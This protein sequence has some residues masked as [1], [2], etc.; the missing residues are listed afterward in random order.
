MTA[1][2]STSRRSKPP[3]DRAGR[4]AEGHA[5][6]NLLNEWAAC[7]RLDRPP[8]PGC[9]L[10]LPESFG[11]RFSIFVDTE[12]EFDWA[13]PH[14]R[15]ERSTRTMEALPNIHR[16]LRSYGSAPIYLVD[17][18]VATDQRCV[19]T[20][21]EYL[22]KGECAIGA[23]LHPWVNPPFDEALNVRNSFPGNLPV[24]T[25]R[26]KIERLTETIE[27]AFG[28][29]PIV[30][31]AG[32][33]GV[34][35]NTASLLRDAGYR[36]DVSVRALFDYTIE[37]GPD[38]TSVRPLPYRIGDGALV[39]LPLTATYVGRLRRWGNRLFPV[40]GRLLSMR[41][42]LART[43]L[44]GRV[45]LTPEGMPLREVLEA[46]QLMIDDG[47]QLF[48]ISFHSPS[49][50]PGHTPYVRSEADLETFYRWWDGVMDFFV[51]RGIAPASLDEILEATAAAR[52]RCR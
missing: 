4:G 6:P 13:K 17:H 45:A 15:Q 1:S 48:S 11:R 34:G 50:E 3:S 33:Y 47:V 8:H 24:A 36:L 25:E 9:Y 5:G 21:R 40:S 2:P 42:L 39:E 35:P 28:R 19:A 44:L 41:G 16:R 20:L 32:R 30:Y 31:R 49:L 22:E 38:F 37:A 7:G 46:M 43:G 27:D 26:A 12:E 29:R 10:E 51:R 14:S 18:P 52:S 23:Q